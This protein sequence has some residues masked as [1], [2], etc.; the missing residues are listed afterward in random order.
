MRSIR[1]LLASCSLLAS[2]FLAASPASAQSGCSADLSGD[3]VVGAADLARLLDEWGSCAT[4]SCVAG[5]RKR[6]STGEGRR[7]SFMVASPRSTR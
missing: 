3:G 6:P 1:L 5:A 7:I 4:K 2:L